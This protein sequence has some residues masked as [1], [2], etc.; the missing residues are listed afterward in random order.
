MRKYIPVRQWASLRE[1]KIHQ[2]IVQ[3]TLKNLGKIKEK[4]N[5]QEPKSIT[6]EVRIG[7]HYISSDKENEAVDKA[8]E[9]CLVINGVKYLPIHYG[10]LLL[11][12]PPSSKGMQGEGSV[13]SLKWR[14]ENAKPRT[15]ALGW[16]ICGKCWFFCC[17]KHIRMSTWHFGGMLALQ[18]Y[19]QAPISAQ[20]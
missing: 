4:P 6:W 17:S 5:M 10:C 2:S 14:S 12:K 19:D 1:V 16:C 18:I 15:S 8:K 11:T 3:D 20:I 9:V 13:H 7:G